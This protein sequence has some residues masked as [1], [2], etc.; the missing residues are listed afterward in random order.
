MEHAV[1][2]CIVGNNKT[3][4]DAMAASGLRRWV[5]ARS[6]VSVLATN[7]ADGVYMGM[8]QLAVKRNVCHIG[9]WYMRRV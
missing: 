4:G 2:V 1:N 7:L 8:Y 3:A 9:I 6:Y 5:T